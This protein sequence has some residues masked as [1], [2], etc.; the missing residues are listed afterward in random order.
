[1]ALLFL[2]LFLLLPLVTVFVEAFRQGAA[3][4]FAALRKTPD[5]LAAVRV[6]LIAAEQRGGVEP[7]VRGRGGV[8]SSP[9]SIFA[10]RALLLTVIDLPFAVSPIISGMIF[11]LL[12]GRQS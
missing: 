12:F 5:T 11:A 7:R 3:H 2:A 4:Y 8:G 1:M 10:A 9:S 6:T